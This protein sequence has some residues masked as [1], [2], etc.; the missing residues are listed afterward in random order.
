ML[1]TRISPPAGEACPAGSD[2]WGHCDD[3]RTCGYQPRLR[4]VMPPVGSIA[5]RGAD[6]ILGILPAAGRQCNPLSDYA[7]ERSGGTIPAPPRSGECQAQLS[8][9]AGVSAL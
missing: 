2:L 6:A 8:Q 7:S 3:T 1:P 5:G 4:F 9:A